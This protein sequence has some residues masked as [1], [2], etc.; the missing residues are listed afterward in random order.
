MGEGDA[1]KVRAAR[2][3]LRLDGMTCR[4]ATRSVTARLRDVPGVETV[5]AD[6]GSG[7]VTVTGTMSAVELLAALSDSPYRAEVTSAAAR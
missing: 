6:L 5:L 1:E 4:H 2:V 3:D 7:L